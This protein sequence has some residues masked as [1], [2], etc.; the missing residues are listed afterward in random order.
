ME[1][2][3]GTIVGT[4]APAIAADLGAAPVDVNGAMTGYLVALAAGIP[5][6]RWL[7]DRFGSRRI[8]LVGIA[9][10]TVASALCAASPSLGV[11]VLSRVLQGAGGALMVPV[12]RLAVIRTTP[13]ADLLAAIA[14]LTWPGLLAPVLAPSLAGWIVTVASW[15]WIFLVNLPLGAAAFVAAVRLVPR[16]ADPDVGPLDW[17]GFV[18]SAGGLVGVLLGVELVRP[19]GDP[20]AA[21]LPLAVGAV[22]LVAAAWWYRRA[23]HRLLDLHALRLASFR[24]S[25]AGGSVYR[26]VITAVPFLVPL[27]FQVGFGWSPAR[28]GVLLMAL[29]VGNVGIKPLTTPL[30]R[31]FGFR[32]VLL[33]AVG[34]GALVLVGFA[35]LGPGTPLPVTA[36]ALV[37]SGA[38][39]SIGFS[40]YN[41]LQFADVEAP[42]LPGANVVSATLQQ[43]AGAVGIS[44]A[45]LLLR[46]GQLAAEGP[47]DLV[48]YHVAF[49]AL[50]LLML[51]PLLGAVRLPSAVGHQLTGPTR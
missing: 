14:Y 26:M 34:G 15:H 16:S 44:V 47:S 45:A 38:L 40:A 27:L 28:A 8:F 35:F 30:L 36:G 24:A 32:S 48:A 2:L 25:N 6:S 49:V 41:S 37:L 42:R 4:A 51:I 31:R 20:L 22:L 5:V 29:F 23:P 39:R 33:G 43:V 19:T 1:I 9:V 3:D 10:F 7:A 12:G 17:R 13:R 18:L 46:L 11:L 21:V 50:A